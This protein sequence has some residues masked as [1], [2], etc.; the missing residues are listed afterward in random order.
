MIPNLFLV[1]PPKTGTSSLF[2]LLCQHP[3]IQGSDP[4]ETFYLLDEDSPL[5][6]Q[7]R[8]YFK[9]GIH[10]WGKFLS[11]SNSPEVTYKLEGTT[12]SI[13]QKGVPEILSKEIENPRAIMVIRNPADRIR[14]SFFY[15]RDT[16]ARIPNHITFAKYVDDLL[17]SRP[18]NFV[19]YPKSKYVLEN[20]IL[21]SQYL[22]HLQHWS[23]C[24]G[25]DNILCLAFD[26]FVKDQQNT[27]N[28]IFSWLDL[29]AL[30]VEMENRNKTVEHRFPAIYRAIKKNSILLRIGRP[31]K[32]Y[33]KSFMQRESR[34]R[35]LDS[36]DRIAYERL[37]DYFCDDM[38]KIERELQY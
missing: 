29:P 28:A 18:L 3:E 5:L 20:E 1:G 23:S 6:N 31:F 35:E 17:S 16:L 8:N 9:D 36:K 19:S 26:S 32:S 27:A 10:G 25:R 13:Y 30:D 11:G 14:S 34:G 37:Q 22:Q 7:E 2:G 38:K 24:I 15:S 12:H 4:K 33:Y 21:I